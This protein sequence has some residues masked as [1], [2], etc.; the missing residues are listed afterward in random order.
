MPYRTALPLTKRVLVVRSSP[1]LAAVVRVGAGIVT[2]LAGC[3][4]S[5]A[6]HI[7]PPIAGAEVA[8]SATGTV[9]VLVG[10]T[11]V[12][13]GFGALRSRTHLVIEGDELSIAEGAGRR[14]P[15]RKRIAVTVHDIEQVGLETHDDGFGPSYRV[16]ITTHAGRTV[17][18]GDFQTS[19]RGHQEKLAADIRAFVGA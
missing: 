4:L 11:I 1:A 10:L 7:L 17:A 12:A 5:P 13:L 16:R 9:F 8:M 19:F 18:V 15:P 2:T 3:V 14:T 6:T